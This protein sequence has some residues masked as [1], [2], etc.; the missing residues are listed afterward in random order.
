[1]FRR[2][3]HELSTSILLYPVGP[4][5]KKHNVYN[6]YSWWWI[7]S[8]PIHASANF[9]LAFYM[10]EFNDIP[11]FIIHHIHDPNIV[12]YS[13]YVW[14]SNIINSSDS[15]TIKTGVTTLKPIHCGNGSYHLQTWW[16]R[17]M[18]YD[19]VLPTCY[20]RYKSRIH[21]P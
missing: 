1:M 2:G 6:P 8:V 9:P 11:L 4:S 14:W 20:S 16:S 19:I 18:V 13:P 21:L 10:V 15:N 17:G 7:S 12:V 3:N 5:S